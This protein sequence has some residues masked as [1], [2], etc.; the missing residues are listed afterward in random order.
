MQASTTLS[1]SGWI[2]ALL[3][4]LLLL[5]PAV[6]SV[7]SAEAFEY[8]KLLV[9]RSGAIAIL[10]VAGGA[11]LAGRGGAPGLGR[12]PLV[13]G[14]LALLASAA[15]STVFGISPRISFFGSTYRFSGLTTWACYGVLF[16]AARAVVRD[17]AHGRAL[18]W[19]T[20]A[21]VAIVAG[22]AVLQ[23]AGGDP[24]P[25][26]SRFVFRGFTRVQGSL[27][28]PNFLS[29]YLAA[30][31]PWCLAVGL[32][33]D[34]AGARAAALL[35][36]GGAALGAAVALATLSR[37]GGLALVASLLV[38]GV[39][40][41][42]LRERRAT[43]QLLAA[44]LL[45]LLALGALATSAPGQRFF[46]R[47]ADRARLAAQVQNARR[48]ELWETG[49]AMFRSAPW[50]GLGPDSYGLAYP[51]FQA[52]PD[53][54]PLLP[55][56]SHNEVVQ[57]AVGQ[58]VVGLLALGALLFGA[59]RAVRRGWRQAA[60]PEARLLVATSGAGLVGFGVQSL[61]SFTVMPLGTLAAIQLGVLSGLACPQPGVQ[62]ARE[63]VALWLVIGG[64]ALA[65]WLAL[66]GWVL[67]GAWQSGFSG[68]GAGA[69]GICLVMAWVRARAE[70]RIA[71]GDGARCRLGP[72]FLRNRRGAAVAAAAAVLACGALAAAVVWPFRADALAEKARRARQGGEPQA[73]VAL[74]ERAVQI[75]P[76]RAFLWSEL[77]TARHRTAFGTATASDRTALLVGSRDAQREA[78][79]LTPLRAEHHANLGRILAELAQ[80]APEEATREDAFAAMEAAAGLAPKHV[81]ILNDGSKLALMLRDHT[82]AEGFA[83]RGLALYPDH[84]P[85]HALLG[86]AAMQRGDWGAAADA[87][88]DALAANWRGNRAGELAVRINLATARLELGEPAAAQAEA[89]AALALDSVAVQAWLVKAR[90][91]EAQSLSRG[92]AAELHRE[93]AIQS[94]LFVVR[95]VPGSPGARAGLTRLGVAAG[96]ES[97]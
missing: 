95:L 72:G 69:F 43:R 97:P 28:N 24:L 85:T 77:A 35:A 94:Y 2:R 59:A 57:V 84:A 66:Q 44:S 38:T 67:T 17:A 39:G 90:A 9:L 55:S 41:A 54:S 40:V 14:V 18:L 83:R 86:A 30:A 71:G 11:A 65:A 46:E 27:G 58:G 8:P 68:L 6:F 36:A 88:E 75:Q 1:A 73:A 3:L 60:G 91:H 74:L 12:D 50:L 25:W 4:L 34:R 79:R 22:Y 32:A 82:A 81:V 51:R 21:A 61:F 76:G 16:F 37:A 63:P 48:T 5:V 64:V 80:A 7:L 42:R 29:A 47:V 26:E 96:T 89:D 49:L 93:A 52:R 45:A 13:W 87:L 10:A 70:A 62:A 19:A 53:L 33:C 15:V 20:L 56:H 92:P 78:I 23:L 31:L